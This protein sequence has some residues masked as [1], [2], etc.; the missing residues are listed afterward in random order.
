MESIIKKYLFWTYPAEPWQLVTPFTVA[1]IG[2]PII[3]PA[4][5]SMFTKAILSRPELEPI[6]TR[7]QSVLS[8]T[9]EVANFLTPLF[10][11]NFV[12]RS[13][14]TIENGTNKHEITAYSLY[15]PILSTL[16]IIGF[17][18]ERT[19]LHADDDVDDGLQEEESTTITETT[20][21]LKDKTKFKKSRRSSLL[22]IQSSL[23]ADNE[24]KK[25]RASA[26][27]GSN[28]AFPV[29]VPFDT[30][31]EKKRREKSIRLRKQWVDL[32]ATIKKSSGSKKMIVLISSYSANHQQKSHQDRALTILKGLK[33]GEDQLETI[34]G[35]KPENKEKR[36]ELFGLSGIRAKYPQFFLVDE[37]NT[38]SFLADFDGF[39]A[40]HEMGTLLE[41]MK[42][43]DAV[44]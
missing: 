2:M 16:C 19:V 20:M 37:S 28:H 7:L 31:S 34:D 26:I 9:G 12:L 38:T 36:N 32:V 1:M 41:T 44:V 5:Q 27:M 42:L 4:L 8:M 29:Y 33:I 6:Q 3:G 23:S 39:E 30:P 21:L 35:A 22:S 13:P 15:V 17:L 24:A 10:V 18:Y 11:G 43:D 40:M 25:H 14:E